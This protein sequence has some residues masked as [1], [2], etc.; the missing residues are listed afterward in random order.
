MLHICLVLNKLLDYLLY[1]SFFLVILLEIENRPV[2]CGF[3]RLCS[4]V[5]PTFIVVDSASNFGTGT[6]VSH[7]PASPQSRFSGKY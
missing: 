2:F 7:L 1:L 6:D 5:A 3:Y 4:D